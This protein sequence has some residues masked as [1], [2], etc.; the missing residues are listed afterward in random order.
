MEKG[1]LRRLILR[2]LANRELSGYE[3]WKELGAK[4]VKI[5]TNYLYMILAEMHRRELLKGRWVE[6]RRGPR[7]HLYTPSRKGEEELRKLLAESIEFVAA[8]FAQANMTARNLPEHVSSVRASFTSMGVPTPGSGKRIVL[9]TPSLD[10]L[11]CFP[12]SYQA[13]GEAFPAASV[14]VVKPPGTTFTVDAP[15]VTFLDGSRC[16]MPMKDGFADY[17]LLEG[18]PAGAPVEVTLAECYRVLK[19]RGYLIIRLPSVMTEEK[20]PNFSN[21]AE[22]AYRLYYDFTGQDAMVSVER[23]KQL[24][25][26]RSG[27]LTDLV[28]RGNVVICA[29]VIKG[30]GLPPIRVHR[31]ASHR[32]IHS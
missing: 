13:F 20:K 4:G 21:L 28:D 32:G 16:N 24:L 11:I 27:S 23:I 17:L 30:E 10:P 15:N 14:V 31:R 12:L 29:K 19:D 9:T 7:R 8:A 22:F 6:G 2:I 1:A 26:K 18:F 25:S 3:A 5:R